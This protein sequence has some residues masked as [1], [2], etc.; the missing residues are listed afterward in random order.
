MTPRPELLSFFIFWIVVVFNLPSLPLSLFLSLFSVYGFCLLNLFLPL[1][2]IIFWWR[3]FERGWKIILF[4]REKE[5]SL[6]LV[7]RTLY[8]Q[9]WV[10]HRQRHIINIINITSSSFSSSASPVFIFINFHLN[11]RTPFRDYHWFSR[12]LRVFL[13]FPIPFS[14]LSSL[15]KRKDIKIFLFK[16]TTLCCLVI[17]LF[18]L[19]ILGSTHIRFLEG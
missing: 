16:M 6:S 14:T 3:L 19:L 11:Y 8:S 1:I 13:F 17:S 4:R 7:F 18:F 5:L 15:T 10:K 2:Y 12:V 9:I